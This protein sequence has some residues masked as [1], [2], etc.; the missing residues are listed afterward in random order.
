MIEGRTEQTDPQETKYIS[1]LSVVMFITS[2]I[3]K[4]HSRFAKLMTCSITL[5]QGSQIIRPMRAFV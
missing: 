2:V 5:M 3:L 4:A 1:L